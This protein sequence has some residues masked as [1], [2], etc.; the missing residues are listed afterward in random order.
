VLTNIVYRGNIGEVMSWAILTWIFHYLFLL[1]KEQSPIIFNQLFHKLFIFLVMFFLAHNIMAF[2]GSA[3]IFVFLFF[4]F[5]NDFT[6]W[7][8]FLICFY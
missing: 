8:K 4:Y 2:F 3:L 7:K 6:K 5:K 1:K